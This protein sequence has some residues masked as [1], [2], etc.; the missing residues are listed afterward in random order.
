VDILSRFRIFD[1]GRKVAG[2]VEEKKRAGMGY[3]ILV[4]QSDETWAKCERRWLG[5]YKMLIPR[6]SFYPFSSGG[7]SD[8]PM[9]ICTSDR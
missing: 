5:V 4:R 7:N 8:R 3:C 9:T 1:R 2:L 6:S